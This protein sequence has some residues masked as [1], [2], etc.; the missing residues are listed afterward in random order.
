MKFLQRCI[1]V[2]VKLSHLQT[3]LKRKQYS[4]KKE[5]R[6][7]TCSDRAE[8]VYLSVYML[9]SKEAFV[10]IYA[11]ILSIVHFDSVPLEKFL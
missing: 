1:K 6:F 3:F 2:R 11:E 10:S 8:R 7:V 4:C 9:A 5:P